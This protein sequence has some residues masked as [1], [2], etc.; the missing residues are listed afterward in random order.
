ELDALGLATRQGGRALAQADVAEAHVRQRLELARNGRYRL[1]EGERLLDRHLQHLLDAAPLVADLEGL[2]VVALAM[3]D[4]AGHVHV[5]QE[6]HLDLD[7]PVALA[8]FA[9]TAADVEGKTPRP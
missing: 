2:A 1:E 7:Q 8:G 3:A 4:I 9:A 6:V 5:G